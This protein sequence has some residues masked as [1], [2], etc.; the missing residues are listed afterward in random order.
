MAVDGGLWAAKKT[1]LITSCQ[2]VE[3]RS[4]SSLL[5]TQDRHLVMQRRVPGFRASPSDLELG[6]WL[7]SPTVF[8]GGFQ[9]HDMVKHRNSDYFLGTDYLCSVAHL[10]VEIL[11]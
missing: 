1:S 2:L 10:T 5:I 6:K 11:L 8:S 3:S 7:F 4:L 9:V